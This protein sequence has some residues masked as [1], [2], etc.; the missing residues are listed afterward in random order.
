MN[1]TTSDQPASAQ[2]S[3][4]P[5]RSRLSGWRRPLRRGVEGQ[6]LVEFALSL[7]FLVLLF[8]VLVE[9]GFLLRSHMTVTAATREAVRIASGRGNADPAYTFDKKNGNAVAG[10]VGADGDLVLVQ[11]ANTALQDERTNVTL[12]MTYRAD[13]TE[14]QSLGTGPGNPSGTI[15]TNVIP[16]NQ[17]GM[18]GI[19]G[20]YG[21]YYNPIVSKYPFMEVFSYTLQTT[22]PNGAL[23][24]WFTP[25]VMTVSA[26]Q[27]YYGGNPGVN[28]SGQ[29]NP[30]GDVVPASTNAFCG[31]ATKTD[32]SSTPTGGIN[33]TLR[34][35]QYDNTRNNFTSISGKNQYN[36]STQCAGTNTSGANVDQVTN[37]SAV[38]IYVVPSA[39]L[40][41]CW[42]FNFAPW[43]PSLRR[44]L[45]VA[46]NPST[47]SSGNSDYFNTNK[48]VPQD[49]GLDT[50]SQRSPDYI[51]VRIDYQHKSFLQ[52]L[53]FDLSLSDKAVK[54]MD[55]VGGGFQN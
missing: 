52:F 33:R 26:C 5:I 40:L 22:G 53:P 17:I 32:N 18:K 11:N 44:T 54:I 31:D 51:G 39:P 3:P 12:L 36:N 47:A 42:R 16:S 30:S 1:T 9:T 46:P 48:D 7:P 35:G 41:R 24:K 29:Q 20:A 8:V 14:G 27:T 38:P 34:L 49:F 37:V 45:D 28:L 2:T 55:P 4:S 50:Q 19:G 23:Q 15:T 21:I 13:T 6:A 43:Y 25:T 10:R